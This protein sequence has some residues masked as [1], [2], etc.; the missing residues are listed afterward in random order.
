MP[1]SYAEAVAEA[2]G[3][4]QMFE[5]VPYTVNGVT[6]KV[7]KNAPPS[8]REFYAFGRL[9]GDKPFVVCG[10]AMRKSAGQNVKWEVHGG[11]LDDLARALRTREHHA[12]HSA[13][14]DD[15]DDLVI[16]HGLW[17]F[18]EFLTTSIANIGK[19]CVRMVRFDDGR[20]AAIEAFDRHH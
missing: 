11:T 7:F 14:A 16:W 5:L 13:L 4:G 2:T 18:L 3:P 9:H 19:L 17:I 8:L 6:Y 1:L 15:A 10:L 12:A 20:S